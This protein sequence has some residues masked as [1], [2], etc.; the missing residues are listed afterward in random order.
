MPYSNTIPSPSLLAQT[1]PEV[2]DYLLHL[3]SENEVLS[4]DGEA[5]R[6]LL[7]YSDPGEA[8]EFLAL[9]GG[10]LLTHYAT[11]EAAGDVMRE[12]KAHKLARH[13]ERVGEGIAYLQRAA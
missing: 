13:V 2:R 3:Q 5:L 1:P 8:I 6:N 4:A 9:L 11:D 10:V 7:D 12:H